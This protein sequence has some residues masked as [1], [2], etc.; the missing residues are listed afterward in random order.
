MAIGKLGLE[1]MTL[2]IRRTED[3]ALA[4]DALKDQA[5]A[6]YVADSGF[7][8][9]NET[10]I[11]TSALRARLPTMFGQPPWAAKGGVDGVWRQPLGSVAAFRRIY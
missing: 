11:N 2:R 1:L 4:F 9:I 5:D 7:F 6:L 8:R 10:L 3:I